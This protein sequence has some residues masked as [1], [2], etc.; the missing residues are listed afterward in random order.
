MAGAA[1]NGMGGM[2]VDAGVDAAAMDANVMDGSA[3]DT[4]TDS[5][6]DAMPVPGL[7]AYDPFGSTGR[8][9]AS[10]AGFGWQSGWDVQSDEIT[11]PGFELAAAMPLTYL[12]LQRTPGHATGGQAYR[13]SGRRF[14][15]G[16]QGVFKDYLKDGFIG[17]VDKSLWLSFLFR[18]DADGDGDSHVSFGANNVPWDN[19]SDGGGKFA[20]GFFGA[21]SKTGDVGYWSLRGRNAETPIK[22]SAVVTKGQAV[23]MVLNVSFTATGG[24]VKLYV[25]PTSLGGQAPATVSAEFTA[26]TALDFRNITWYPGSNPANGAIDEV[27]VG[28]TYASVTPTN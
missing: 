7:I 25:N 17:A 1:G 20:V 19:N 4:G 16:A 9:N 27:R 22:T 14:D 15:V 23:F 10:A 21:A 8:L 18:R 24:S 6:V 28:M 26:T 13:S 3:A 11:M 5:G 12:T 2:T